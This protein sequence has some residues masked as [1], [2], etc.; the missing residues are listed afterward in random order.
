MCGRT[1]QILSSFIFEIVPNLICT[2]DEQ[3][4]LMGAQIDKL[5]RNSYVLLVIFYHLFF[6]LFRKLSVL[7]I[8][9]FDEFLMFSFFLIIGS[10]VISDCVFLDDVDLI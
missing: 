3:N 6:F 1:Y 8:N 4:G 9:S 10:D 7:A 2:L 5:L